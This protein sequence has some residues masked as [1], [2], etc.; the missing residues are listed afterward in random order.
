MTRYAIQHKTNKRYWTGM[1]D[2]WSEAVA[3]AKTFPYMSDALTTAYMECAADPLTYDA[4]PVAP[5]TAAANE[6][7]V[8]A[9]T[10]DWLRTA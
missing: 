3:G 5:E 2:V 7:I 9:A 8:T 6:Q 10:A 4:V 1:L